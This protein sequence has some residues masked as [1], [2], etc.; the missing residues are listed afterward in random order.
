[1][2]IHA[3]LKSARETGLEPATS[4]VTGRRSNQ[5]ELLS[6]LENRSYSSKIFLICLGAGSRTCTCDLGLMS[7]SL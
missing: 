5:V 2:A 3:R 4:A 6:Q 7:P 1:M